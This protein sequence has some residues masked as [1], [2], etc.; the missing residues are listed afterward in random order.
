MAK[1]RGEVDVTPED[2]LLLN[3][4]FLPTINAERL[5]QHLP[6]FTTM[7]DYASFVLASSMSS[8]VDGEKRKKKQTIAERYATAPANIQS[9]VDA[10]LGS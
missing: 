3:S 8:Y 9:Q 10:L 4:S 6:L 1:I 2:E 7:D 5:S